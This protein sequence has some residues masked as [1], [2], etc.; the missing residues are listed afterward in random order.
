[1]TDFI[2]IKYRVYF[3]CTNKISTK[4]KEY[5]KTTNRVQNKKLRINERLILQLSSIEY[6]QST[7][8]KSLQKS[9][10]NKS[11]IGVQLLEFSRAC[12]TWLDSSPFPCQ[13][14]FSRFITTSVGLNSSICTF[15]VFI[16]SLT[17][18]ASLEFSLNFLSWTVCFL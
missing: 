3:E 13:L 1:M 6:I 14:H 16:S 5:N 18:L 11:T 10:Y 9:E 15:S 12:K 17:P 2:I 4:K 8:T 7:P